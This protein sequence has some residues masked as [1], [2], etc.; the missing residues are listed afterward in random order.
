MVAHIS[1][2]AAGGIRADSPLRGEEPFAIKGVNWFGAEGEGACPDGLWQRPAAEFL[3][4][5]A[6]LEFNAIR[7]PLAVDNVLDD[8]LVGKW[9]LTANEQL[10]GLRSLALLERV[11]VMAAARGL[12]VLLD[13]HR[14]SAR[15]WPTAHGLWYSNEVGIALSDGQSAPS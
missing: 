14:L 13:V 1:F 7:L 9:S 12:L 11:V 4:F 15:V 10:R 6:E 8:P 2:R 5:V 3:D